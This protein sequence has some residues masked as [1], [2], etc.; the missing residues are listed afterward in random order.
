MPPESL[1]SFGSAFQATVPLYY[2]KRAAH[3]IRSTQWHTLTSDDIFRR[4]PISIV[5]MRCYYQYCLINS[6]VHYR[7]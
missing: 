5:H 4:L 2:N 3:V 6:V 7:E 1:I